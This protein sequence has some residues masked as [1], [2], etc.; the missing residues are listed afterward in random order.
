MMTFHDSFYLLVD[1][2][3]FQLDDM[4]NLAIF[5]G[6]TVIRPS[7]SSPI[8]ATPANCMGWNGLPCW[9]NQRHL[10]FELP[11]TPRLSGP[12]SIVLRWNSAEKAVPIDFDYVW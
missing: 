6:G 12:P 3:A 4:P 1:V 10:E 11:A 5:I 7:G 9:Y 8:T 2:E